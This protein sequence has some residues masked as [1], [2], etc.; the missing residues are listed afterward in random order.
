[1]AAVE[2]IPRGGRKTVSLSHNLVIGEFPLTIR[3]DVA[4]LAVGCL[5]PTWVAK[6]RAAYLCIS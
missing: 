1:V 4:V 2:A 5:Y 6:V 3:D